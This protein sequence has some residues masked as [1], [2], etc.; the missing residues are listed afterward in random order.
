MMQTEQLYVWIVK[1]AHLVKG[2]HMNVV[3]KYYQVK[4]CIAYLA[5]KTVHSPT[6]MTR[7]AVFSAVHPVQK[8]SWLI[9]IV[10]R[11]QMSNVQNSAT[12]RTGNG[13]ANVKNGS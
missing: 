2:F 3:Q 6:I 1:A 10:Q 8:I 12:A 13:P 5:F 4:W 9:K 7:P 11:H